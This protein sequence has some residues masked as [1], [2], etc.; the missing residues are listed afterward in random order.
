MTSRR[1]GLITALVLTAALFLAMPGLV[2][3][4]LL[5]DAGRAHESLR[6]QR[7]RTLT[8]WLLGSETGDRALIARAAAAYE[9]AHSGVRIFLRVVSAEE[10]TAPDAVLPDVALYETGSL[11]IPEK[12]FV[13]L[14]EQGDSSGMLAGV[15]Y[16]IPLWLSPNVL[17]LPASWLS[18]AQVPA[19]KAD[20]L[21]AASTPEP[22]QEDLSVLSPEA[23]PW[24]RLVQPGA[25]APT[26]GTALMQLLSLCPYPLRKAF[27]N[28]AAIEAAPD[29]ARVETLQSHLAAVK[30]GEAVAGCV[31]SPAV[32]DRVR[33][34]SLCR[35]SKE[36]QAFVQFLRTQ[37]AQDALA[38]SLIPLTDQALSCPE[39]LSHQA[40]LLF[41]RSH[42]LP[43][44]F[45][46]TRGELLSLCR[47]AFL[48]CADPVE[49]LLRLR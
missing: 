46:H 36:A 1:T 14:A 11:N 13:P 49:T 21:L 37:T 39:A 41:Q 5:S 16:A 19:P 33:Y 22:A 25:I 43:N 24:K 30:N 40:L 17:T 18:G 9:K 6:P 47:D 28:A 48:R 27:T 29:C 4:L 45:A 2:R 35:E 10:F 38:S 20:S 26:E 12:V 42:T 23:L 15:S 32:S 7:M 44:A 8:V 3:T 34:V 31:L